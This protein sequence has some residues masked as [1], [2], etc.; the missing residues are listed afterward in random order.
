MKGIIIAILV[1]LLGVA[2]WWFL[3][4]QSSTNSKST[5]SSSEKA[6]AGQAI[7]IKDF[8]YSPATLTVK[9][10]ETVTVTNKDAAGHSITADDGSFDTGVLSQ[11]EAGTF[12]APTQPGTYKFHCTPHPSITGT[13]V[14]Q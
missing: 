6:V 14:V 8:A 5:T 3:K 12:T 11:N 7:E 10:G 13:L 2:G 4:P 1:I 9:A